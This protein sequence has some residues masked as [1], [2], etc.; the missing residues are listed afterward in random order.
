[1]IIPKVMPIDLIM[2]REFLKTR[3]VSIDTNN[4]GS[5]QT[6]LEV[7]RM[8]KRPDVMMRILNSNKGVRL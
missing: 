5:A 1:M 3:P 6:S 2:E 8:L 4:A 7:A